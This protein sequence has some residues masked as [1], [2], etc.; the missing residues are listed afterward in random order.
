[1]YPGGLF[2]AGGLFERGLNLGGGLI[3]FHPKGGNFLK[4]FYRDEAKVL[5]AILQSKGAF[6]DY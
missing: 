3:K 1:M 4:S 6:N 2:E 5:N